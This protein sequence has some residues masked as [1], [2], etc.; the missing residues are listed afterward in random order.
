MNFILSTS[1][2]IHSFHK[3]PQ[4]YIIVNYTWYNQI[5]SRGFWKAVDLR[6]VTIVQEKFPHS[7]EG[8]LATIYLKEG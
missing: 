7:N 6:G 3:Y 4:Q 2:K 8:A 1:H 5:L